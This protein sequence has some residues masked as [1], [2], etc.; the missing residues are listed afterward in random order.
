MLQDVTD[1]QLPFGGKVVVFGGDF[2]QVFLVVPRTNRHEAIEA[3]LVTSKLWPT[4]QKIKLTENM[5]EKFDPSF[6]KFLLRVGNG[7][8]NSVNN[9]KIKIPNGMVIPYKDDIT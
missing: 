9:D 3:S 2:Q 6:S 1:S 8:E 7:I 4:L 5:R